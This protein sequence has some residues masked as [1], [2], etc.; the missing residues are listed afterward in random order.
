MPR[1]DRSRVHMR[2]RAC[3]SRVLRQRSHS[4]EG[5]KMRVWAERGVG[6]RDEWV[7]Y[8]TR[9]RLGGWR[10]AGGR[11]RGVCEL[12]LNGSIPSIGRM[13]ID[14]ITCSYMPF[15]ATCSYSPL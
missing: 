9:P 10:G 12:G 8:G 3:T 5:G 7:G 15:P 11:I 1:V 6:F 2:S 14:T 4:C 13:G